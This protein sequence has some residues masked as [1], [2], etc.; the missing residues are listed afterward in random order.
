MF[1]QIAI[2]QD[3][4]LS[5]NIILFR[6]IIRNNGKNGQDQVKWGNPWSKIVFLQDIT[7]QWYWGCLNSSKQH[8]KKSLN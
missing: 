7:Y 5:N 8:F 1:K 3:V 4:L 2:D 6:D